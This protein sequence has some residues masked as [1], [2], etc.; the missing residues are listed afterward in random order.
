MTTHLGGGQISIEGRLRLA[1][2]LILLVLLVFVVRLFQ[3]QILEGDELRR[4]SERNS[5][6][7]I[8]LEAPRGEMLDREG[9]VLAS[10]RPAYRLEVTPNDLARRERTFAALGELLGAEPISLDAKAGCHRMTAE[11]HQMISTMAQGVVHVEL[12]DAAGG[13][14]TLAV[15][16]RDHDRRA[17]VLIDHARGDDTD[18]AGV[19]IFR[20]EDDRSAGV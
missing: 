13:P 17:M 8:R 19:P 16:Y 14:L 1:A 18:D 10:T 9:R 12:A 11:R 15:V 3:L 4:R 7:Q 2:G 6:R 5:V 20:R